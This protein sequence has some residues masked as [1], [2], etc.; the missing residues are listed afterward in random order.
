MSNEK[1]ERMAS[2]FL[3]LCIKWETQAENYEAEGD[4]NCGTGSDVP[5]AISGVLRD[6]IEEVTNIISQNHST[7]IK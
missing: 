7:P 1:L 4:A 5:Y 2:D 6:N 3:D